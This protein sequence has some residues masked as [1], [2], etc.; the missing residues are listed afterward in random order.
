[1]RRVASL[2]AVAAVLLAAGAFSDVPDAE[3]ESALRKVARDLL[4]SGRPA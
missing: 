1:M 2:A 4:A 3:L